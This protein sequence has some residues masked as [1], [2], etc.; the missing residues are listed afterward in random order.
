MLWELSRGKGEADAGKQFLEGARKRL[1]L[2][3]RARLTRGS[4]VLRT[5]IQ[6]D[7]PKHRLVGLLHTVPVPDARLV[8]GT[9]EM[10][11]CFEGRLKRELRFCPCARIQRP[12]LPM[13]RKGPRGATAERH[14]HGDGFSR[15]NSKSHTVQSSLQ[16]RRCPTAANGCTHD[17]GVR[18][19][20]HS[21]A[22]E[23]PSGPADARAPLLL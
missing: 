12:P 5:T 17:L 7:P 13:D 11:P 10:L 22:Q 18:L 16:P 21:A 4:D 3:R 15:L 23:P 9:P 20:V 14:F 2:V 6:C 1:E 8:G 19:P